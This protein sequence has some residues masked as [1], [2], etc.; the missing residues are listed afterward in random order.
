MLDKMAPKEK[1]RKEEP[2]RVSKHEAGAFPKLL[3]LFSLIAMIVA[4]V[5]YFNIYT[6]PKIW[7]NGLLLLAGLW[8]F[9]AG[10]S[11]GIKEKRHSELKKYL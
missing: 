7:L 8:L 1:K 11:A 3:L 6:I 2:I 10:A 9:F 5:D 4:V